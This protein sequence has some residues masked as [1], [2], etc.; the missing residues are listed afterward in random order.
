MK[1]SEPDFIINP[2]TTSNF[3]KPRKR[4]NSE[5]MKARDEYFLMMVFTLLLNR[6][7]VFAILMFSVN[8]ETW[9]CRKRVKVTNNSCG[10]RGTVDV[11]SVSRMLFSFLFFSSFSLVHRLFSPLAMFLCNRYRFT[12]GDL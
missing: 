8:K 9:Q 4:L 11:S 7:H 1:T 3:T 10:A 12:E 2:F 5:L 6:V